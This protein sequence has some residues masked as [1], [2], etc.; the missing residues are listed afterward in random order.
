MWVHYFDPHSP[1]DFREHF[2]DLK[3]NG[4]A[5]PAEIADEGMRER[6]RNYDT[7]IAY[8]D[9][10]IGKLLAALDEMNLSD[11]TLIVLTG[12][13]GE[14]LGEHDYV[15][16]GRHLY[17]NIIRVPLIVRLPGK[18]K[19][20]QVVPTPVSILDIAPT[21]M[22]L[23]IKNAVADKNLPFKFAGRTL[24]P[25]LTT[26]AKLSQRRVYTVTFPGKKG[27]APKWLSWMWVRDEE[28]PL[29]FGYVDGNSKF[30]WSP[31]EQNVAAYDIGRD[32]QEMKPRT[33]NVGNQAYKNQTARLKTWFSRTES[34]ASE[35]RL[36][37]RDIDVLKSLGYVQ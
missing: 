5:R 32:P 17:E 12:D 24:A 2:A 26:G 30:I 36:T 22:D 14:S 37:A 35:E 33:L 20:A 15:G 31:E 29:R 3:Q 16:H 13:H 19:A 9:W 21:V 18:V 1:Y 6:V 4:S 27:F 10:H 11:S 25:T 34:R 8:T 23:T 7:E 28:L